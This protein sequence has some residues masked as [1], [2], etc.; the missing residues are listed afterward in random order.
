MRSPL[1]LSRPQPSRPQSPPHC[2]P[3][4]RFIAWPDNA[5]PGQAKQRIIVTQL[6]VADVGASERVGKAYA[7]QRLTW[8]RHN[9]EAFSTAGLLDITEKPLFRWQ[10]W[11]AN[12]RDYSDDFVGPG[13]ATVYVTK[14]R[15]PL[16]LYAAR[17]DGTMAYL[18]LSRSLLGKGWSY[19]VAFSG[20]LGPAV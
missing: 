12:E 15:L 17:V 14:P 18:E 3:S 2:G 11:V 8:L 9:R 4:Q 10:T 1:K 5:Q 7:W 19:L 20:V 16:R 6:D 13:V